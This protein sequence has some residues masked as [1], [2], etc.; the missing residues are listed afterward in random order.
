MEMENLKSEFVNLRSSNSLNIEENVSTSSFP[1]ANSKEEAP[2][3]VFEVCL[4]AAIPAA[5]I[6]KIQCF[7]IVP[8]GFTSAIPI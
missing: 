5:S 6:S 4:L 1:A 2:K 7:A 3:Q 8:D